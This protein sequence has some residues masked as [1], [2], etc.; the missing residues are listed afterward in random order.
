MEDTVRAV[1]LPVFLRVLHFRIY[2]TSS[3]YIRICDRRVCSCGSR[4]QDMPTVSA[5]DFG[6]CKRDIYSA[7][8]VCY[9][10]HRNPFLG[11]KRRG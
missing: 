6:G 9:Y 3:A 5:W 2:H 10:L 11:Y 8:P 1:L 7:L 4:S